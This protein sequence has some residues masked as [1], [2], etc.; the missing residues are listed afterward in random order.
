MIGQ[1]IANASKL[2]ALDDDLKNT[3]SQIDSVIADNEDLIRNTNQYILDVL[4]IWKERQTQAYEKL[5]F[6]QEP[7]LKK[8]I[9]IA[10][11]GMFLIITIKL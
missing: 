7:G 5:M 10:K 1:I 2:F 3:T 11:M 4:D 6:A 9:E 8:A